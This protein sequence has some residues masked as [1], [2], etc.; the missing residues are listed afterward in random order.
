MNRRRSRE[1]LGNQREQKRRGG[2]GGLEGGTIWST[3]SFLANKRCP[4]VLKTETTTLL[5]LH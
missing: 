1:D 3:P 5:K 2:G 4:N